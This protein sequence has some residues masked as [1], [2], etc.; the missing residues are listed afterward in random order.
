M[1]SF[2]YGRSTLK[3]Q[4]CTKQPKSLECPKYSNWQNYQS[5]QSVQIFQDTDQSKP[6]H[7]FGK[8]DKD[9]YHLK[10]CHFFLLNVIMTV[11]RKT[12]LWG[13]LAFMIYPAFGGAL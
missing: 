9:A 2:K 4:K 7:T 11:T 12:N 8:N 3:Q 10:N 1:K 13:K 6:F 5:G